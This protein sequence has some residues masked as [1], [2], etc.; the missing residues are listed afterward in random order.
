MKIENINIEIDDQ[1]IIDEI[2]TALEGG[3]NYWYNLDP[4]D[5]IPFRQAYTG[6]PLSEKVARAVL[7]KGIT[8]KIWDAEDNEELLGELS[9]DGIYT[10]FAKMIQEYP[11]VFANIT[12]QQSDASDSDI[13][14]QLAVMNEVK[15]G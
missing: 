7:E 3:S 4:D 5:L 10:G 1:T 12:T 11:Y 8:I 13:L 6:M 14:L 2:I 9:R 15:F